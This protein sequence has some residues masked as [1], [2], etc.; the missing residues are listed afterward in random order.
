MREEGVAFVFNTPNERSR[1]GYLRM[2]WR[3]VGRVPAAFRPTK[4]AAAVRLARSRVPAERWSLTLSVG[5]PV[6]EWLGQRTRA[7][8]VRAPRHVR[9][10]HTNSSETY[11]RWRYGLPSLHYR[12]VD[13]GDA[14]VLVRL[15]RRG[16]AKE[17]SVVQ[18]FG[19]PTR[20]DH[21]AFHVARE[22]GADYVLRV[23]DAR[24]ASGYPAL[25]S[26]GPRLTWRALADAG[27]PPLPNWALTLGDV[28]LF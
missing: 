7:D 2:G 6:G 3:D 19:D 1:H 22:A 23:G 20:A 14:A 15:R 27:M 12:V 18:T 24:P 21:L 9:E 5:T 25:P 26:G 28:E 16:L 8:L 10:L 17:L 13:D 11:L 4:P